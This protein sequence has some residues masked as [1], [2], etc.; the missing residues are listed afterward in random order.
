M[1]TTD[2][3]IP[4]FCE[5]DESVFERAMK[6]FEVFSMIYFVNKP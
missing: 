1:A 3:W 2:D 6:G 4:R 5:D